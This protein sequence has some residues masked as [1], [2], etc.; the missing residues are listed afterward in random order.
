[1][2]T[3]HYSPLDHLI[4]YTPPAAPY[5]CVEP[6]SHLP[7]AANWRDPYPNGWRTVEPGESLCA[8]IG[9]SVRAEQGID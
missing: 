4:V 3:R 7:D 9:I 6:V 5:F 2:K 1:M 8:T